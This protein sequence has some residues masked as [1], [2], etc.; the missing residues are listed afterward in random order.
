[1]NISI[2]RLQY[3]PDPYFNGTLDDF[4]IYNGALSV[5]DIVV[6]ASS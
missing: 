3:P 4:R 2:A 5:A 1:M 6:L